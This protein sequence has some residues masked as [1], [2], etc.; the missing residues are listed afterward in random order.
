V[1]RLL[2]NR[3]N[4]TPVRES[5]FVN[6]PLAVCELPLG[7]EGAHGFTGGAGWVSWS[8]P[9]FGEQLADLVKAQQKLDEAIKRYGFSVE[10]LGPKFR[11]QEL[12]RCKCAMTRCARPRL[13]KSA[14]CKKHS[15]LLDRKIARIGED[16]E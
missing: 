2:T 5:F 3:C 13:P 10:E 9:S 6:R 11:Q 16:H 15:D 12:E 14:L 4:Y 7:H 8:A 1:L